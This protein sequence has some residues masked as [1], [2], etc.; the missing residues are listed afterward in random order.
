MWRKFFKKTEPTEE[1]FRLLYDMFYSRVYRDVYFITRDTY[2]AQDALQETFVK[3]YKH[4]DRIEDKERIGAWLSTIA[5]RTAI[6]I[7]R[8][9][10]S[11]TE[12]KID[13]SNENL[14]DYNPEE[15]AQLETIVEQRLIKEDLLEIINE[16]K[17]EYRE[18][19][20]LKYIHEWSVHEIA[21]FLDVKMG[22]VKTRLYRARKVLKDM[23]ERDK[24]RSWIGGDN[25]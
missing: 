5:T 25:R 22:T 15:V 21:N 14:I 1:E 24:K 20:L 2:L 13:Q 18:I 4:M 6:D 7:L 23:I 3:A 8:K 17:P 11:K 10:K 12:V 19:I 9:R 16:L